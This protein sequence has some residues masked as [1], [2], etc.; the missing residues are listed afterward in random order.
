MEGWYLVINKVKWPQEVRF[1]LETVQSEVAKNQAAI[2]TAS[3][4]RVYDDAANQKYGRRT[5]APEEASAWAIQRTEAVLKL[6]EDLGEWEVVEEDQ[7]G[8]TVRLLKKKE[9][10]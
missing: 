7:N 9:S 1:I 3:L 4:N 6:I 10:K 5:F 2:Y 8:T